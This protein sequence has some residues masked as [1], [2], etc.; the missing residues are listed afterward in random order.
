[1]QKHKAISVRPGQ[2]GGLQRS[3]ASGEVGQDSRRS[4][5][6]ARSSPATSKPDAAASSSHCSIGHELAKGVKSHAAERRHDRG[7]GRAGWRVLGVGPPALLQ[8]GYRRQHDQDRRRTDERAGRGRRTC[9]WPTIFC[10]GFRTVDMLYGA[11][12]TY[13]VAAARAAQGAQKCG[14]VKVVFAVL[15]EAA[16]EMM[17]LGCADLRRGSAACADRPDGH[18]VG[19][20][21][22]QG[23]G[24]STR[25]WWKCSLVPVTKANLNSI[26]KVVDAGAQGLD[27]LIIAPARRAHEYGERS[28]RRRQE[29]GYHSVRLRLNQQQLEL[30][31]NSVKAGEA[32]SREELIRRALREF[33]K[34]FGIDSRKARA[35]RTVAPRED[36]RP[37]RDRTCSWRN[38]T[39]T[40]AGAHHRAGHRQGAGSPARPDSAHRASRRPAMRRLQLLQSP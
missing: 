38:R 26:D 34:A 16:E 40:A 22:R 18:S 2:S 10:S 4:A 15:G 7:A 8:G 32:A 17:R 36:D 5:S 11:D 39:K 12:D 31:D 13:G 24:R 9:R 33:A 14:K 30:I 6:A 35:N 25:S 37:T 23:R 3:G 29:H 28:S 20:Q 1:M 21:A 19:G 27:A